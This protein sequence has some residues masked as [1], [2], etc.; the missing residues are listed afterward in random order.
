MRAEPS[1]S[2]ATPVGRTSRRSAW[3]ADLPKDSTSGAVEALEHRPHQA[4]AQPRQLVVAEDRGV[5]GADSDGAG[6]GPT[7]QGQHRDQG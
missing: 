2:V 4:P 7:E 5:L 1:P 3:N 6:G